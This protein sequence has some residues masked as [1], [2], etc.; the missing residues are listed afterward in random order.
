MTDDDD[1]LKAL[2]DAAERDQLAPTKTPYSNWVMKGPEGSDDIGD[3]SV[4]LAVDERYRSV[5][6]I[7]AWELDARQRELVAAG[8]HL[9]MTVW[10]HPIPP[11]ALAVEAP[12]C[13]VCEMDM[14]YVRGERK[15]ACPRC[16]IR[17]HPGDGIEK[18]PLDSVHSDFSPA[19]D[20]SE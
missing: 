4:E 20:D 16:S 6:T 14:I 11:L 19:E 1:R 7:S 8:A 3:L 9:R 17:L 5:A 10:Q 18:T 12:F 2:R 15:F 13:E